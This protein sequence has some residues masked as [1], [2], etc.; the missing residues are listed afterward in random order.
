MSET[1]QLPTGPGFVQT[2]SH[3]HDDSSKW[4]QF[5]ATKDAQVE[6]ARVHADLKNHIT[7]EAAATRQ[8]VQEHTRHTEL[9]IRDMET[10][11]TTAALADSKNEVL[12]LRLAAT[13]TTA[14]VATA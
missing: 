7:T 3:S 12:R 8:M 14:T 10:R 11:A 9:L 5:N 6:T 4:F 2:S 13:G 1:I